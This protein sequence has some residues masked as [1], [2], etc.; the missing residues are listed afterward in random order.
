MLPILSN[1]GVASASLRKGL[2]RSVNNLQ[3]T[4]FV[5]KVGLRKKIISA[6]AR[7][8]FCRALLQ[9]DELIPTTIYTV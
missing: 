1:V 7:Q 6:P 4:F 5:E 3:M 9:W 2:W 8:F